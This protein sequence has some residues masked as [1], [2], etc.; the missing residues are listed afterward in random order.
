MPF[1]AL[2]YL[3]TSRAGDVIAQSV[4]ATCA[5]SLDATSLC[6]LLAY[7]TE[8]T[9]GRNV[10]LL[11]LS[12][13]SLI[14]RP[15]EEVIVAA[16]IPPGSQAAEAHF[17]VHL[18]A[19]LFQLGTLQLGDVHLRPL[20]LQHSGSNRS[21]QQPLHIDLQQFL[22]YRQSAVKGLSVILQVPGVCFAE[23]MGI[24]VCDKCFRIASL[25]ADD[26]IVLGH[27]HAYTILQHAI[28]LACSSLHNVALS[29]VPRSSTSATHPQQ[30]NTPCLQA[31][32]KTTFSAICLDSNGLGGQRAL[33]HVAAVKC[34]RILDLH[35]FI[36]AWSDV[37]LLAQQS[38]ATKH[39]V[40]VGKAAVPANLR[41]QLNIAATVF[42]NELYG[43][44]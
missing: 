17:E 22:S 9:G 43:H 11:H 25:P 18:L 5:D 41:F 37:H 8:A 2:C 38:F 21:W 14:V 15:F 20:K 19:I 44:T 42:K 1:H 39:H 10:C 31:K 12:T 26:C 40:R 33:H 4:A 3:I 32:P 13:F 28:Y 16:A 6:R 36:L 23:L 27:K 29:D 7:H 34:L 30:R 35:T 24:D